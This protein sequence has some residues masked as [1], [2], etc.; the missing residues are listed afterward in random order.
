MPSIKNV[1]KAEFLSVGTLLQSTPDDFSGIIL[2]AGMDDVCKTFKKARIQGVRGYLTKKNLGIR[3]DILLGDPGLLVAVVYPEPEPKKYELGI[4]PHFVDINDSIVS[5]WKKRFGERATIIDVRRK[6]ANVIR[7]IKQCKNVIS[8][9][10]HGLV[11]ADA[12]GIPNIMYVIRRNISRRHDHKY[13]DYYSAMEKDLELIEVDGNEPIDYF[14]SRV[15]DK[16]SSVE[17]LKR[18]LHSAYLNLANYLD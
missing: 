18:D 5:R 11:T 7:D 10:L 14:L 17:P 6:P 9:S 4:V 16:S 2:G 12:F 15:T 8:S 3:G 1:R 13:R